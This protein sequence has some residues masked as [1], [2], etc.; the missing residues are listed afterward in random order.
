MDTGA[1]SSS[2]S[3]S[4]SRDTSPR[5]VSAISPF[6][7]PSHRLVSHP[8]SFGHRGVLQGVRDR[9]MEEECWSCLV[10]PITFWFFASMTLILGF[11]GSESLVL[12]PNTSSLLSANSLLVKEIQVQDNQEPGPMMYGFSS[13]PE[14]NVEK[15]WSVHH[16]ITVPAD[17]HQEWPVWLNRGSSVTLNY[18]IWSTGFLDILIAILRGSEGLHHWIADPMNSGLAQS[19]HNVH[20]TG[21][22]NFEADEDED[23]FFVIG[24]LNRHD[25]KVKLEIL[26]H[27]KLYNT[28]NADYS[29]SLHNKFCGV[30]LLFPGPK[31]A[32]LTTPDE[33]QG[34]QD[35][36]YIKLSYGQRW[37]TYFISLGAIM[38]LVL[39]LLRIASKL[40][41]NSRR[42]TLPMQVPL[43]KDGA[44]I[45]GSYGAIHQTDSPNLYNLLYETVEADETGSNND[46]LYD[47][48]TCAVCYDAPRA[49]FFDPCGH[50]VTCYP[51]ALRIHSEV[52]DSDE[53]GETGACP[54][55]RKKIQH[56]RKIYTP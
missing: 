25:V 45:G 18:S 4:S 41:S 40:D 16:E 15:N 9:Q 32:L 11:Y 50:C 20:G 33:R 35:I 23:Y 8:R 27:S 49:S 1:S 12:G 47:S 13:L 10:I 43:L 3:S 29:C 44:V 24:N 21:G 55:C 7:L 30:Q 2:T 28:S 19:W 26:V 17:Y 37:V 5:R 48:R 22:F 38:S 34:K 31:F 39:L 54:I 42:L 56:V 6:L 51:C 14:L 52:G 53:N 36:W 46:D